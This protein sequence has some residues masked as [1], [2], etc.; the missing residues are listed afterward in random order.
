LGGLSPIYPIAP[1][2][3]AS[4]FN[5]SSKISCPS[6]KTKDFF[7]QDGNYQVLA[8][9]RFKD[10]QDGT[11]YDKVL[12]GYW[13]KCEFGTSYSSGT[14]INTGQNKTWADAK[15]YCPTL[16]GNLGKLNGWRLPDIQEL[17]SL[18]DIEK[19]SNPHINRT[20]F[21]NTGS[22]H[23]SLTPRVGSASYS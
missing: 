16:D 1:S 19:A 21:P 13:Q 15:S 5:G 3:Q 8:F 23:W 6:D 12:N 22:W 20:I 10:L 9:E 18:V 11:V 17:H 14:C 7:G 4:C 2:P